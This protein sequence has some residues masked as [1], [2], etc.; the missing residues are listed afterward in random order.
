LQSSDQYDDIS[1]DEELFNEK[2]KKNKNDNYDIMV[3]RKL[4]LK[5]QRLQEQRSNYN[6]NN[7]NQRKKPK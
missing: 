6:P 4:M 5:K 7:L 3:H 1:S 2:T